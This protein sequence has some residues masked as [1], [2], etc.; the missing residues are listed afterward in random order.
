MIEEQK[1]ATPISEIGEFGLIKQLTKPFE[2]IHNSTLKGVGDDCAVIDMGNNQCMLLTTDILTEGIH[3]NLMYTPL[4][5]LGYKAVAVNVSD[6]YAMNGTPKQ[7]LV[8]VA[9]SGKYSIEAMEELYQ[10]IYHACKH[11]NIDLVGGDTSSS[12]TGMTISITAIGTATK[13]EIVYRSGAKEHDLICVSGSL[14]AAF[15]GLQILEREKLLFTKEKIQPDLDRY[16]YILKRQ[17]KPEARK[18]IIEILAKL[19]VKP[20]SMIDISDGLSSELMHIC[21]QSDV[22]CRIY[23][24]KLPIDHETSWATEEFSIAPETAALNGGEDYELLFTINQA[25]YKKIEDIKEITVIG[26][27]SH[28]NDGLSL[29]TPDDRAISLQAQGWNAFNK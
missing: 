25:D 26:H 24:V 12:L 23:A 18:D 1:S 29:I 11:Y 19:K 8:S 15:A 5:H 20:T 21:N 9:I 10:G 3:F 4:K 13:D 6:I 22:G 14:G 7:I 17:L 28:K 27:I 16:D 2:N